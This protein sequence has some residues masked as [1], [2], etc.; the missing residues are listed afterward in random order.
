MIGLARPIC[1]QPDAA[2]SLL[3]GTTDKI[4]IEEDGLVIGKG[5]FGMNAQN[6]LINLINTV[7][8]VEYYAWQMTR[9]SRGQSPQTEARANALGYF[10]WYLSRTTF[11][12]LR[13]KVGRRG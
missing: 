7:S 12:G 9:M 5:R 4:G 13:R 2:V 6:W 11:L 3:D 10:V 8:R 1:V